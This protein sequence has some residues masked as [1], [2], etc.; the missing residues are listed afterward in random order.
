MGRPESHLSRVRRY[1]CLP[2]A[3]RSVTPLTRGRPANGG[4]LLTLVT[5]LCRRAVPQVVLILGVSSA[6]DLKVK[7]YTSGY[8]NIA[9]VYLGTL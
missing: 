2:G 4:Q 1:I 9:K 7:Y 6:T 8:S 5:S 3:G